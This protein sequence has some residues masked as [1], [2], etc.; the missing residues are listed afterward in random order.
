M[1][2]TPTCN[3]LMTSDP[4]R[5]VLLFVDDRPNTLASR[6]FERTDYDLILLRHA[7]HGLSPAHLAATSHFPA[8]YREAA[9]PDETEIERFQVWCR[10]QGLHPTHLLN[11]SEPEQQFAHKLGQSLGLPSLRGEQVT[12]LRN[13]VAMKEKF[14]QIGFK[15]ADYREVAT[16]DDLVAAGRAFNWPVVLKPQEGFACIDTYLVRS[17]EEARQASLSPTTKWMAESFVEGTEWEC[18]ALIQHGKVLD[19]Y[20]SAMPAAPLNIV[21]GA[22]NA[23][24]TLRPHPTDFPVDTNRMMQQLVDGMSLDHGYIHLEF[25]TLASRDW[26]MGEAALRLAGCEIPANH[27]YACRFNIFDALID[28][29]LGRTPDMIYGEE[30]CVGDLLLPSAKGTIAFMTPKEELCA[31][32]GVF[33]YKPRI[34]VG[35]TVDPRRASHTCSAVVHV[36]GQSMEEVLARMEHVS[37]HYRITADALPAQPNK[38]GP[39][40]A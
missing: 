4:H 8:F 36:E 7:N 30:R 9:Q 29:H 40:H 11:P 13:K 6:V 33:D 21:D 23:N 2:V 1:S 27:G 15:T 20:L 16:V 26:R 38:G 34:A 32:P 12:W 35:Q 22:I 18:C 25:F 14:R 5:E 31:M 3:R 39:V 10:T 19:T 17:E 37:T 28:I 24:I